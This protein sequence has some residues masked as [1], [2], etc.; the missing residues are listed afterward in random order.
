M[1]KITSLN[2]QP[3]A[4]VLGV[5]SRLNYKPWYAIAEFV[6]NSTQSYYS[7]KKELNM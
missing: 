2:I 5:F 7:N 1:E 6:D 4:G 3:Q